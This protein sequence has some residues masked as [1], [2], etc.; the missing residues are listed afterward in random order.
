VGERKLMTLFVVRSD[1]VIE[2][3]TFGY[4]DAKVAIISTRALL[5]GWQ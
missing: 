3:E 5:L 4:G 2:R 1:F